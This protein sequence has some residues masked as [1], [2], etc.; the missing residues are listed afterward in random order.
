MRF[1]SLEVLTHRAVAV[2]R[3]FPWTLAAGAITATMAILASHNNGDEALARVAFVAALGLP[4]TI[5]LTLTA[6]ARGWRPVVRTASLLGGVALLLLFYL[7]WPGIDDRTEAIRY[8]QLAVALHLVVAFLPFLAVHH[9]IAFWQ[10]NRR[11][12]L[13]F[14]RAGLFSAVIFVG[15]A[16][17][18]GALD[19]LFGIDVRPN[20]Y[21]HIWFVSAFVVNSWIF[22]ASIPEDLEALADDVEYPKALKVLAQYILTPLAFGYLLILLAYLVKIVAGGEWPNGWIGWLVASVAVTGLLGF[23]LVEPL[24]ADPAE[25]WIRIYARWLFLGL[26]PA[27]LM[28]LTAF[29]KRIE[30]YGLTEPRSLGLLLGIWLLGTAVIFSIRPG[31]SIKA[32]PMSLSLLLAVTLYG[33]VSVTRLS[34]QS[35]GR[36]LASTLP[37]GRPVA[38]PSEASAALRFLID[39]H[40]EAEIAK[41]LGKP[42]PATDWS[43]IHR[44]GPARDSLGQRLMALAGATYRAEGAS[45]RNRNDFSFA[46]EDG[47]PLSVEGFHW[48]A[49]V[50]ASDTARHTLGPDSMQALPRGANGMVRIAL[51][52]DTLVFDLHPLLQR[53]RDSLLV[54]RGVPSSALRVASDSGRRAGSLLLRGVSG[55][56]LADSLLLKHWY[57]TVLIQ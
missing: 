19:K 38:D 48:L 21:L 53:Y 43:T 5:A 17:A 35:Q 16:I 32:I 55:R 34:I 50:N 40:A 28:L 4:L 3:R 9:R 7:G 46:F 8:L 56:R 27:S 44:F 31:T 25:G 45:L 24:R 49:T 12:F 42:F 18:L 29:W 30:P 6:E 54:G 47:Q 11:L 14:L 26:I 10:Y 22:V 13:G 20:A 2:L 39:H 36:R 41:R 52:V 33:P 15:V 57:G 23:L 37:P 1:P 51:G